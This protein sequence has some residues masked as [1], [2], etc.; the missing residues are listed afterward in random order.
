[1]SRSVYSQLHSL[2]GPTLSES[3]RQD[4]IEKTLRLERA[5]WSRR[6]VPELDRPE[7]CLL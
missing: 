6:D 4:P 5:R 3:E 1:M 7:V 2:V